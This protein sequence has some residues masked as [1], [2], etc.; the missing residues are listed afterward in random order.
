MN[1]I[2]CI[3]TLVCTITSRSP[4]KTDYSCEIGKSECRITD[5]D[6][7]AELRKKCDA[8]PNCLEMSPRVFVLREKIEEKVSSSVKAKP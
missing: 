1:N 5:A 8:A 6:E 7:E 4:G 3:V 2:V